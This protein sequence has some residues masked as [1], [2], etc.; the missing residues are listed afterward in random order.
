ML[1]VFQTVLAA[2]LITF[3]AWLS[4]KNP[5]SAGL[6]I[7]MP[8]SSMLVLPFSY[9]QHGDGGTS[10]K[11]AQEILWAIPVSV[12]FFIPFALAHRFGLSFGQAYGL[13]VMFLVASYF[14][15]KAISS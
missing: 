5:Q 7:A 4:K 10:V 9:W 12:T 14:V 11:L 1:Q 6:L 13:G 3:S 8:I 15:M 2:L